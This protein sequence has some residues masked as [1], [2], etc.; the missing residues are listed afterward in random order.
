M[1]LTIYLL[2][3]LLTVFT[4]CKKNNL[5]EEGSGKLVSVSFPV[6][7]FS[8][9]DFSSYGNIEFIQSDSHK[10]VIDSDE[11]MIS[12]YSPKVLDNELQLGKKGC[13]YQTKYSCVL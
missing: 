11:N 5:C 10:V 4:S 1:K 7:V 13:Y 8:K 3:T 6:E 2:I 9:I 12:F